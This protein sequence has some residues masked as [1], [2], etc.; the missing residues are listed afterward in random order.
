MNYSENQLR[1]IAKTNS[2]EF[3]RILEVADVPT[4]VFGAEI[5]GDEIADEQLA[6][7]VFRRLLKHVHALVRESAMLGLSSF[8]LD[9]KPPQDILDK[10]AMIFA[11]DPSTII[12]D[13]AE[14][15]L[16]DFAKLS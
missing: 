4:L 7:P 13:C 16:K 9:K 10:L 6:L 15:L 3:L 5:L 2:Q 8:Y 14:E 11:N 12:R 1:N